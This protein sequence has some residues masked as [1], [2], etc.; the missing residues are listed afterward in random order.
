[1]ADTSAKEAANALV[2][3]YIFRYGFFRRCH[4]DNGPAFVADLF[5]N[6]CKALHIKQTFSVPFRP[7]GNSACERQNRTMLG[8]LRKFCT[9]HER[10]WDILISAVTFSMKISVHTDLGDTPFFLFFNRD[11]LMHSDLL[12]SPPPAFYT[13][14]QY[15]QDYLGNLQKGHEFVRNHLTRRQERNARNYDK[16]ADPPRYLIGDL[17]LYRDYSK[18]PSGVIQKLKHRPFQD[19]LFRISKFG[20]TDGVVEISLLPGRESRYPDGFQKVVNI[21]QLKPYPCST[22]PEEPGNDLEPDQF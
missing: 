19:E 7:E 6:M 17:V 1:M 16:N 18:P 14:R 22:E 9:D 8:V 4:S 15:K 20:A 5:R 3:N 21:S 2:Q 13:P 11:P 10:D 12:F